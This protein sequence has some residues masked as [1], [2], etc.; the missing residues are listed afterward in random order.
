MITTEQR[1]Y[2]NILSQNEWINYVVSYAF[3]ERQSWKAHEI[4]DL[5]LFIDAFPIS[6]DDSYTSRVIKNLA[7]KGIL[8]P[9]KKWSD[10]PQLFYSLTDKGI[11]HFY[12]GE[13]SVQRAVLSTIT[14]LETFILKFERDLPCIDQIGQ[15]PMTTG[16]YVGLRHYYEWLLLNGARKGLGTAELLKNRSGYG[17]PINKAYFY[18][19]SRDLQNEYIINKTLSTKGVERLSDLEIILL[20]DIQ[21]VKTILLKMSTVQKLVKQWIKENKS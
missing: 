10:R 4:H 5:V 15:I 19:I 7:S 21:N 2:A 9:I 16:G 1:P 3:A 6:A 12:T 11:I 17:K 14:F 13:Y 20:N 8:H 18:Q